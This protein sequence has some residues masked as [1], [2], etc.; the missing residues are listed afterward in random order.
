MYQDLTVGI[1]LNYENFKHNENNF[2]FGH[3]GYFS[4]QKYF[5]ASIPVNYKK[6]T[7]N[8]ELNA[9]VSLGYQTYH[10]NEE[11]YFPTNSAYQSAAEF[12]AGYGFIKSAKHEAKDESG[13]GG[14]AKLALDYYLLDDLMIGG[15]IGYSTFGEYKEMSEMLYIKSVL[16]GM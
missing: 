5:V 4:P 12:L 11:D 10:L 2:T 13:I 7:E 16:G 14:S 6:R 9:N 1:D 15:T 8:L 3:G